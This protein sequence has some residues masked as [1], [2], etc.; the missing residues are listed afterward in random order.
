MKYSVTK[1]FSHKLASLTAA[2]QVQVGGLLNKMESAEKT[3]LVGSLF[4]VV[5]DN[6]FYIRLQSLRL[7]GAFVRTD[8]DEEFLFLDIISEKE[9]ERSQH[10]FAM[11]DPRRNA[12]FNPSAN[13]SINPRVNSTLNP[14][15]NSTLNPRINSIIN[16]QINSTLNPLLNS[17]L[18]PRLNSMIN[19]QMN[20][21]INPRLNSLINPRFNASFGGPFVYDLELVQKGFQVQASDRVILLFDMYGNQYAFGIK[22]PPGSYAL[23][24]VDSEWVGYTV[25][26]NKDI[27]LTFDLNGEWTGIIV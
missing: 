8:G 11:R 2:D 3:D 27:S 1:D 20:S 19:P 16:P 25:R 17:T 14:R 23:F 18:N 7:I 13:R 5:A 9:P 26:A 12:K 22:T 15:V 24:N 10:F 21:R 4:H 6:V